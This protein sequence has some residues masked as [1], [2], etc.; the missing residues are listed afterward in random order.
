MKATSVQLRMKKALLTHYVEPDWHTA[1]NGKCGDDGRLTL[2]F[3]RKLPSYDGHRVYFTIYPSGQTHIMV[4]FPRL[5][6]SVTALMPGEKKPKQGRWLQL[7]K[8]TDVSQLIYAVEDAVRK[9]D[10]LT[11]EWNLIL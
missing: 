9:Y 6:V 1:S 3:W 4:S 5:S 10:T 11:Q 2:G 8:G 7:Y